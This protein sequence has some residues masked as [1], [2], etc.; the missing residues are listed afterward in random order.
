MPQHEDPLADLED[1]K[2]FGT[3]A[4]G[5]LA[6]QQMSFPG[7]IDNIGH[8]M[9]FRAFETTQLDRTG[10]S[11]KRPKFAITLPVPGNLGT[12]YNLNYTEQDAGALQQTIID[13]L[14]G[15][16]NAQTSMAAMAGGGAAGGFVGALAGKGSAK[17]IVEGAIAGAVGAATIDTLTGGT[18]GQVAAN[19]VIGQLGGTGALLTGAFGVARNPHKVVLFESVGFRTHSFRYEFVPQNLTEAQNLREIIKLFKHA[20]S[21]SLNLKKTLDLGSA[22]GGKVDLKINVSGGKHFFGYPDYFD[23]EFRHQ[24]KGDAGFLF[25][26]GASVLTSIEVDYHPAGIPTY[27]RSENNPDDPSPTSIKLGLTFKETE[28]VT[29]ENITEKGR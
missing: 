13:A 10:S 11:T 27:A 15:D 23:I 17:A 28:I 1:T 29:K 19:E 3:F 25:S 7:D 14:G 9:I 8:W 4:T 12:T 24:P 6:V 22:V 2:R 20:A 21:P 16:K 5:A 18:S 26:I